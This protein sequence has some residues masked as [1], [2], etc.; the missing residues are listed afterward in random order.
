MG[1]GRFSAGSGVWWG[2]FQGSS[3]RWSSTEQRKVCVNCACHVLNW[4]VLVV[5][6]IAEFLRGLRSCVGL[7]KQMRLLQNFDVELSSFRL[8]PVCVSLH[9]TVHPDG[10]RKHPRVRARVSPCVPVCPR[11][12]PC[13]PCAVCPGSGDFLPVL[14]IYRRTARG[15]QDLVNLNRRDAVSTLAL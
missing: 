9:V 15:F 8:S 13:V 14:Y 11:V 6:K 4:V 3:L 12:S 5:S 2:S 10:R 1:W 7:Q